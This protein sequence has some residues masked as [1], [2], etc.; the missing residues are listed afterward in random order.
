VRWTEHGP[1]G[2]SRSPLSVVVAQ[3]LSRGHERRYR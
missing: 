3:T 2:I 1:W